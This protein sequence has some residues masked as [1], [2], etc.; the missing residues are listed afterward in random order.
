MN[1]LH[2]FLL[3]LYGDLLEDR[4]RAR[5]ISKQLLVILSTLIKKLT[6]LLG[7]FSS[8]CM[9]NQQDKVYVLSKHYDL[10]DTYS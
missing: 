7:N 3:H 8:A 9:I 10:Q 1:T 5:E 4:R 2:G 6:A